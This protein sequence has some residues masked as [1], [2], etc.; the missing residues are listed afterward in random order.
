MIKVLI[1]DMF[2]SEAATLVNTVNCVGVMGKGV[3]AVFKKQF[4]GMFNDYVSRCDRGEVQPGAPYLYEDILGI[5]VLNFPTKKHW[6]SPSRLQYVV[7]GLAAF[8]RDYKTWGIRS[9][10]FPPLGCGNGGLEWKDVGPLMYK[11]LSRLDIDV[12]IYAPFGTPKQQLE[13]RFLSGQLNL[14]EDKKGHKNAQLTPALVA[15]LEVVNRLQQQPYANPVGRTI[16]QKICY[17]FTE[18]GVATGF[19]FKKGSYGP[20]SDDVKA[21]LGTFANANLITE[22]QLG[23]MTALKVSANFETEKAKFAAELAQYESKISKTVDLFSRIKTTDQAEEVTTILFAAREV[24]AGSSTNAASEQD[25]LDFIA[26][27]KSKWAQEPKRSSVIESMRNLEMLNWLR[28]DICDD[29]A[30]ASM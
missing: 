1:G 16:F 19:D 24:K 23:R 20:F 4:P 18:Q 13:V 6:R 29:I 3:A 9:I 12:E 22:G 17:I 27:W 28:L 5:S 11:T 14:D 10:A 2:Q 30:F 25:V 8:E 26:S 15:L 7:D 21:A